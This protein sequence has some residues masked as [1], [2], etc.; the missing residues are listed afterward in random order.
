MKNIISIGLILLALLSL[1]D[2]S[3]ASDASPSDAQGLTLLVMKSLKEAGTL[4]RMEADR[5]TGYVKTDA[6]YSNQICT[7]NIE[8]KNFHKNVKAYFSTEVKSLGGCE[9]QISSYIKKEFRKI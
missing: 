1:T 4:N 9:K 5:S 8:I 6:T 3:H 7:L 2:I